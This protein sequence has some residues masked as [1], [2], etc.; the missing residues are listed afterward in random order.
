MNLN[1]VDWKSL[2]KH[3]RHLFRNTVYSR[4]DRNLVKVYRNPEELV[5]LASAYEKFEELILK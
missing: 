5:I 1:E 2:E 4:M 3:W